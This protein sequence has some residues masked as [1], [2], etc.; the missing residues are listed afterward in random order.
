MEG[1]GHKIEAQMRGWEWAT[2]SAGADLKPFKLF[3]AGL[4][5]SYGFGQFTVQNVKVT[6]APGLQR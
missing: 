4:Y 3:K 6:S 2:I 1:G 5:V